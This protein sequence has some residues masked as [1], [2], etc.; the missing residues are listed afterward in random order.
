MALEMPEDIKLFVDEVVDSFAMWDLLIFCQKKSHEPQI[1]RDVPRMLGRPETDMQKPFEKLR[2][3]DIVRAKTRPDGVEI[4]ELN[5]QSKHL[6]TLKKFWAYN[7]H[8]ENRL[9]ILSYLL[10]R[11]VR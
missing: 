7:E 8:Q 5:L 3:L 6:E 2:D 11:R 4:C 9:K 1:L 10:S